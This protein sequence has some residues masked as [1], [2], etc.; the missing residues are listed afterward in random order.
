[1]STVSR[2]RLGPEYHG[3]PLTYEE[4]CEADW[5]PGFQYELIIDGRL[6]ALPSPNAPEGSWNSGCS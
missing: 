5:Q 6:F 2:L 1:M 4:F 3:R